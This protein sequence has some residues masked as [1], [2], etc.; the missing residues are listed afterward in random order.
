MDWTKYPDVTP[1]KE[2]IRYEVYRE[3]CNKQNY[4]TWNGNGWASDGNTITHY[5]KIIN[6]FGNQIGR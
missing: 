4:C 1:S 2:N 6:P 3:K 5:R